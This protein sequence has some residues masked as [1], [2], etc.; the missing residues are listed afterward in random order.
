MAAMAKAARAM[1]IED[2]SRNANSP[3]PNN[4]VTHHI[5]R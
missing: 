5:S 1:A 4:W 2:G 3:W